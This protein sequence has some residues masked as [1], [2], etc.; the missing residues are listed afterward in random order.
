MQLSGFLRRTGLPNGFYGGTFH[1]SDG[2]TVRDA[3]RL[4]GVDARS[5]WLITHNGELAQYDTP[6]QDRDVVNIVPLISGG[7]L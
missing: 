1:L 7:M 2:A 5:P 6:L 4:A 3:L